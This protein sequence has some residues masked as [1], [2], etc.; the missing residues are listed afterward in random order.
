[1][2]IFERG[3]TV[4]QALMSKSESR[5]TRLNASCALMVTS[6]TCSCWDFE[7]NCWRW[8]IRWSHSPR[9]ATPFFPPTSLL[10][11][12]V[13]S[14]C[15]IMLQMCN[16]F[17]VQL[18][19]SILTGLFFKRCFSPAAS[20]FQF[21]FCQFEIYSYCSCFLFLLRCIDQFLFIVL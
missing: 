17:N 9:I 2:S 3:S 14:T 1:M 15:H 12:T 16:E 11:I 4:K 10:H 19:V 7:H 13:S 8:R 21:F 6:D 5:Q 18:C 20:L